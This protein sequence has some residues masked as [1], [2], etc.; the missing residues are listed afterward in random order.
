MGP[1]G[2]SGLGFLRCRPWWSG[3]Q[4][5]AHVLPPCN[6][7]KQP[8]FLL[9]GQHKPAYFS[10]SWVDNV[11]W[12]ETNVLSHS[13]CFKISLSIESFSTGLLKRL[14][15]SSHWAKTSPLA[16][17]AIKEQFCLKRIPF[18]TLLP[19]DTPACNFSNLKRISGIE[20]LT[21]WTNDEWNLARDEPISRLSFHQQI[22]HFTP[23]SNHCLFVLY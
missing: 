3:P 13:F 4:T 11:R 16:L 6:L 18:L 20:S 7:N 8:Q 14:I 22:P 10:F 17:I 9:L 19:L 1:S 5:P 21:S 23:F 12:G 15:Y 2:G